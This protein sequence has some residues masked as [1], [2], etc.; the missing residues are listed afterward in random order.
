MDI[1][2]LHLNGIDAA[3]QITKTNSSTNMI[4]LSMYSDKTFFS[5]EPEMPELRDTF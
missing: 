1:A 3:A 4:L 5:S 2:M